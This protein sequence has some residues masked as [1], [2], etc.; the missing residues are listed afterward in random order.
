MHRSSDR[1]LDLSP[2][3]DLPAQPVFPLFLFRQI[4]RELI[5]LLSFFASLRV[6]C[7]SLRSTPA[8]GHGSQRTRHRASPRLRVARDEVEVPGAHDSSVGGRR[9]A[10]HRCLLCYRAWSGIGCR[11]VEDEGG[12][13]RGRV[14]IEREQDVVS[15][16]PRSRCFE[17]RER[18]RLMS[19][20]SRLPLL[21][22]HQRR[23]VL[24]LSTPFVRGSR[25]DLPS[26]FSARSLQESLRGSSSSPRPIPT[27]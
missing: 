24:L 3:L 26:R 20:S 21:Q 15:T 13:G 1:E 27:S 10:H 14:E 12:E 4:D 2:L 17:F 16:T 11:W 7:V 22:D 18:Q 8:A 25:A 9:Q 19:I 5:S 6:S 23:L